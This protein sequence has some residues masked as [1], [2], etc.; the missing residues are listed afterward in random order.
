MA[1]KR[2]LYG[3]EWSPTVLA[4]SREMECIR[5][6]G[7]WKLPD[8][9]VAGMGLHYHFR[10]FQE[11]LWPEKVWTKWSQKAMECYL[12]YRIIAVMGPASSGK[13]FDAA[14][15]VLADYYLYSDQTTVL[16]TSTEREML[17]MRV[18]GEIKKYHKL[19]KQRYSWIP[20]N[21]IESRQ[22]IVTASKDEAVD[23]RDFRNGIVGVAC[24]KGGHYQGMGSFIGV[25]NKRVRLVG[26]ELH[27]MPTSYVDV[28]SNLNKN[29][30]F[31]CLGIG[32]PKEMTDALGKLAEPCAEMGGWDSG[33]DQTPLTKTWHTRFNHGVC[34]QLPGSDCP[35]MDSPPG[36][37]P[38]YPFL[39]TREAIESDVRF[40]GKDSLQYTMMDEGRM[41]RG[42]GSR[43]VITRQMCLKFDAMAPPVWSNEKRTHIGG[44]DASYRGVGGDRCIFTDLQFG[45]G[46]QG[47]DLIALIEQVN[48]PIDV[49]KIEL[50]EDQI[51]LFVKEI[52]E[53]RGIAPE[54]FGFDSTG[55]GS[56]MGA[57]ARLWS[58]NVVPIEFGGK[59]SDRK[60]SSEIDMICKDYY[61]KFVSELWFS[62]RLSVEAGQFRGMTEEVMN[63]GCQREWKLVSGNK[64]EIETKEDMK[65]KSGR[66]PDLF[67]SLVCAV[68][69]ARRRGFSIGRLVNPDS[70]ADDSKWRRDAKAKALKL[71]RDK[72]L[73]YSNN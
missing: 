43:R 56:L 32:N 7:E 44:L 18:W 46:L 37:P 13:T 57:F 49:T 23:G 28:I 30:D 70:V 59:A 63:E 48:V 72:E 38:P 39:I 65:L 19:A 36:V 20:G 16:V 10:R 55:R 66:S 21:L 14:T 17:E 1:A 34:L 26:D 22:R 45:P 24:K 60:V 40:Y 50:P 61:S 53:R 67:D 33:I 35:N 8:G 9:T 27:L 3:V 42:L 52:C 31:K 47:G 58:A 5:N 54:N 6:G 4:I 51:A 62:V 29:R 41:P 73:S 68:E 69:M 64:T 15:N 25:K 2:S 11:I 12:D 71:W